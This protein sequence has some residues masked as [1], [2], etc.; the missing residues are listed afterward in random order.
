MFLS[1]KELQELTGY[2]RPSAQIRWLSRNGYRSAVGADGCPKV[3][4]RMVYAKL[5]PS[6]HQAIDEEPDFA[7]LVR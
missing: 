2:Q 4:K 1:K 6:T 5:G 7:A 3:L